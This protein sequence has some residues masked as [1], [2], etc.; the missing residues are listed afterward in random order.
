MSAF[1]AVVASEVVEHV[2]DVRKFISDCAR[3][4]KPGLYNLCAT[5]K[6]LEIGISGQYL[7]FI[8]HSKA[9]RSYMIC[10][11]VTIF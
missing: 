1:D 7:L 4:V 10:I 3:T 9:C 11:F 6:K 8:K 5:E 2:Q